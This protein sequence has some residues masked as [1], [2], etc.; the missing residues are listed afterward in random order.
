M[1]FFT[2]DYHLGHHG[3]IESCDRPFRQTRHMDSVII[4]NHNR[5]VDDNDDVYI[6]GDFTMMTKSHRGQIEQYVRKLK[7]RLHLIM[8]NHDVK[9]PWFWTELGFWSVHAPYFEVE[10]FICVHDPA[11]SQVWVDK[12]FLCGHIHTLF[13]MQ[14]N[15][16][17]VGVDMH[18]FTPLSIKQVREQVL[19]YRNGTRYTARKWLQ[20]MRRERERSALNG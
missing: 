6:L 1:K 17:N 9:D 3:I 10:E 14:R 2:A 15:C 4:K 20:N 13:Y 7:G 12:W 19:D 5:V 11:L 16:L 8:G 18:N